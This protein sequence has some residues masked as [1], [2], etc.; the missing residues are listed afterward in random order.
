M[1]PYLFL[2][3]ETDPSEIDV[4]VHP[5][6]T[7]IKLYKESFIFDSIFKAIKKTFQ[8][9]NEYPDKVTEPEQYQIPSTTRSEINQVTHKTTE[10]FNNKEQFKEI[11][12]KIFKDFPKVNNANTNSQ[13]SYPDKITN[14]F[15][16]KDMYLAF[17][18]ENKLR[19]IDQH[20]AHERI[21]FER[22][23]NENHSKGSQDLLFPENIFVD[24]QDFIIFEEIKPILNKTGYII[25][26]FGKDSL[27]IRSVPTDL[28]NKTDHKELILEIIADNKKDSKDRLTKTYT[29]IAC[30]A[31]I[32]AGDV[33]Q[34]KEK[35]ALVNDW[36]NCQ[37]N[38]SCPHGRPIEKAFDEKEIDKWFHR[39]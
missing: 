14:I 13:V 31:A 17:F 12:S 26:A 4:N 16:F 5:S 7:E 36:L 34:E 38:I 11:Y 1:Y 30:K 8:S 25:D 22:L 19:I 32:K 29:T 37:N 35:I 18:F 20:A 39:G 23:K 27:I 6:K 2:N 3:I 28:P 33:L 9:T 15:Q 24:Q 10:L 21:I